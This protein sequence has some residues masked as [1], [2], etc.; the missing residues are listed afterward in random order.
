MYQRRHQVLKTFPLFSEHSVN[1]FAIEQI[2]ISLFSK[3]IWCWHS[4]MCSINFLGLGFF[5]VFAWHNSS[6]F[7]THFQWGL[8]QEI[9][10]ATVKHAKIDFR[11]KFWWNLTCGASHHLCS[12]IHPLGCS[13]PA[14][15]S[16]LSRISQ[17]FWSIIVPE[18]EE[19]KKES[20]LPVFA[21]RN[22]LGYWRLELN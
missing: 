21:T 13:A 22:I 15:G 19:R 9:L 7:L 12:R 18:K 1:L 8:C 14:Y 6:V 4:W 16:N 20:G 10:A 3:V 17:Y 5:W 11:K 2:K